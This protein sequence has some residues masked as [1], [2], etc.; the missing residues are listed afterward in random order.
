MPR[1]LDNWLEHYMALTENTESPPN[2]HL[3][4]GITA[5][6]SALQR[7]CFC[8]WGSRGYV[9]PNLYIVL[10]GPPGGRKGTA[11][12][13]A[14]NMISELKLF[15]GSDSL[16]SVQ[17]LYNEI[18][19]AEANYLTAKGVTQIHRSLSIWS[20][21][22]QVFIS[23]RNPDLISAVT[24]LFDCPDSWHYT[25]LKSGIKDLSNCFITIIG[26]ITPSLL[27]NKL[28]SDA[29]GGG[30]ISRIIFVVGHGRYKAIAFPMLTKE[31]EEQEKKLAQ[32]IQNIANMKGPFKFHSN[33]YEVYSNWY[34]ADSRS[35]VS[36]E[37]F[38]GYNARR[39]LHLNK[40]CMI[41]SA[42]E[43]NEMIITKEHFERSLAVLEYTEAQMAKAFHGF[44]GGYHAAKMAEIFQ[45]IE[46]Q[47]SFSWQDLIKKFYLLAM[48]GELQDFMDTAEKIKLVKKT[49]T[50][51]TSFYEVIK[52]KEIGGAG[53]DYLNK[54]LFRKMK[55][56]PRY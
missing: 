37:Q 16:G 21:E 19:K 7:K 32:D 49:M 23:E 9:Y 54:T 46:E 36:S 33:F 14:K 48:Q 24:D 52:K 1:E 22:F 56:K 39:S 11:M 4:S 50:P 12:R 20:E 28:S 47:E 31:E 10:V 5:I 40:L 44:G 15:L 38:V 3:W 29:V 6:S 55:E 51:T 2:Y 27:Q 13:V 42:S 25:A 35:G 30:L 18:T 26:A 53:H 34:E 45:W 43:S 8:N 41:F 17:A